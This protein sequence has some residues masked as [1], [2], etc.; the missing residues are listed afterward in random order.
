MDPQAILGR[1]LDTP[2]V[3]YVRAILD[4]YGRAPGGLL[5]NGLA[6]ATLFAAL[7][8]ALLVLGAAG[9]VVG[10]PTAQEDLA[11]ALKELFPPLADFVDQ[12]LLAVTSGAT[13]ASIVGLVGTVWAVSQLY[14]T[15][16]VAFSRIFSEGPER[17][18]VRRTIRGFLWVGGL[19]ALVAGLIVLGTLASL[20]AALFP[21]ERFSADLVRSVLGSPVFLLVV[22]VLVIFTIYRVLPAS[23]PAFHST[24]PAAVVVG[25]VVVVLSQVF[26]VLAP[27]LVGAAKLAGSLATAFIAL[28]WLS[29]TFQALLYGAAWVRVAE[30]RRR[31]V[32]GSA[33]GAAAPPAEPGGGGE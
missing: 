28:A 5:A 16:D 29:F 17:D 4:T 19:I 21:N 33:L 30:D 10:D 20:I 8:V 6:F 25:I 27:I 15:L 2:R 31:E 26:V 23:R 9:L 32:P 24:W 14:V 13:A 18:L 22:G 12:A 1:V 3:A 11:R 7:P